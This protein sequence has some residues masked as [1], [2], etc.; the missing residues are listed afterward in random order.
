MTSS[1]RTPATRK[2]TKGTFFAH[3]DFV[4]TGVVMTLLGPMLPILSARWGLNDTEAGNLFLAQYVSS[5][6]GMLSSGVLVRRFGYRLTLIAGAIL[7]AVGIAMLAAAGHLLGVTAICVYGAGFG[8]TTPACNLFV[9]DAAPEKRASV[10]SLLNSSWGVG[11]MSSP[12]IIA[13]VQRVHQTTAFFYILATSLA[14]LTLSLSAVRFAADAIR[15]VNQPAGDSLVPLNKKFLVLVGAIFFIYVG[16]ETAVGGWVASYAQRVA[17]G[18]ASLWAMT[19]AFFYGAMLGGRTLAPFL[20]RSIQPVRVATAGSAIALLGIVVLLGSNSSA[21]IL[22]GTSLAGL[23]L[24]A[25]F[26]IKISLLPGWFAD[27]VTRIGGFIFASGNLGGGAIPW[28]V[29]VISTRFSNLRA[30]FVVPLLGAASLLAFYFA[31][32]RILAADSR[33]S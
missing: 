5:I 19:P 12:V 4:I 32:S 30:G 25:L 11:A 17:P 9:S 31:Q 8:I 7:M 3:I 2:P 23:G 16:T 1:A 29:G 22:V 10:L 24:S 14:L 13:A 6:A 15:H 33:K 21:T 20:L 27:R 26:P 28:L 18:S